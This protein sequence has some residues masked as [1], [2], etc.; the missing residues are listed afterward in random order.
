MSY[1]YVKIE[2]SLEDEILLFS[3][4]GKD[5]LVN[6]INVLAKFYSYQYKIIFMNIS[7]K[8]FISLLEKKS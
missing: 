4:T 2:L 6:C 1:T 7:I 8:G 5:E 3:F